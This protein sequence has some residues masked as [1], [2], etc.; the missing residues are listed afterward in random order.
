[1]LPKH[2][3]VSAKTEYHTRPHLTSG[4]P[5]W[6]CLWHFFQNVSS[7]QTPGRPTIQL[8]AIKSFSVEGLATWL[9]WFPQHHTRL[10]SSLARKIM[11]AGEAAALITR[12]QIGMSGSPDRATQGGSH[13]TGASHSG[14]HFRGQKFQVSV[15]TGASPPELDGASLWPEHPSSLPINPIQKPAKRLMPAK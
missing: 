14:R 4:Y 8:S 3:A 5:C 13:R 9:Q 7:S 15:F 2:Y 1:M 6:R 10:N 11:S 12:D